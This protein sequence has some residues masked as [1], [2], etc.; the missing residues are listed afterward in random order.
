[1]SASDETVGHDEPAGAAAEAEAEAEPNP[2]ATEAIASPSKAGGRESTDAA[3]ETPSAFA[4]D[5]AGEGESLDVDELTETVLDAMLTETISHSVADPSCDGSTRLCVTGLGATLEEGG[6]AEVEADPEPEPSPEAEP[7]EAISAAGEMA[8][9]GGTAV[10]DP[11]EVDELA[12]APLGGLH[13]SDGAAAAA[14]DG[15]NDAVE[16]RAME[17]FARLERAVVDDEAEEADVEGDEGDEGDEGAKASMR[18]MSEEEE[19]RALQSLRERLR[20]GMAAE[21][22]AI[23][24]R[25]E[26]AHSRLAQAGGE[27]SLGLG[28]RGLDLSV[29]SAAAEAE[30]E[31]EAEAEA[32]A[33]AEMLEEVR[34]SHPRGDAL[35]MRP[36][37][38]LELQPEVAAMYLHQ[39]VELGLT[40]YETTHGEV[41]QVRSSSG[42]PGSEVRVA[43]RSYGRQACASLVRVA[44]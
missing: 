15:A 12:R 32:E 18:E 21:A 19:R 38:Q 3:S 8:W 14:E 23:D 33:A 43:R 9:L 10:G 35:E 37:L 34:D 25:L 4:V 28:M 40:S 29:S 22:D 39:L 2:S 44:V 24:R 41:L 16:K 36:V 31:V 20:Q 42:V 1:M 26:D 17:A 6:A 13:G 11:I 27:G 30:A 7:E 5:A